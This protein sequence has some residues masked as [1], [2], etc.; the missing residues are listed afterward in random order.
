[1]NCK[2]KELN[3]ESLEEVNGGF[4]LMTTLGNLAGDAYS[5]AMYKNCKRALNRKRF[6]YIKKKAS[7]YNKNW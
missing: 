1:M 7:F 4:D 6:T 3:K 2:L 5:N